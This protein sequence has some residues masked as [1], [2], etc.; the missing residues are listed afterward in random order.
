MAGKNWIKGAVAGGKGAL[1]AKA[2]GAGLISGDEKLSGGDLGKLGAAAKKR[3]DTK[4]QKE[5]N[6]ARTLSGLRKGKRGS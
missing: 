1:R 3:G 4:T 2:K 6:L 5:V